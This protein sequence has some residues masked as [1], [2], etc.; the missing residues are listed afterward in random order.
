MQA[1][2]GRLSSWLGRKEVLYEDFVYP[3]RWCCY[4]HGFSY[5]RTLPTPAPYRHCGSARAVDA[6]LRD[7]LARRLEAGYFD[8]IVVT[9]AAN[10]CCGLAKCYGADVPSIL[11]DYVRRHPQTLVATVDGSDIFGTRQCTVRG[12]PGRC[13]AETCHTTFEAELDRVD[14]HFLREVDVRRVGRNAA[15]VRAPSS[16]AFTV[17]LHP[18]AGAKETIGE[19]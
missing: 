5:A 10:N 14:A 19:P 16:G 11:N 13:A 18:D 6:A 2:G 1:L 17:Q 3:H 8:L 15:K 9:V 12:N 7:Q 4:G